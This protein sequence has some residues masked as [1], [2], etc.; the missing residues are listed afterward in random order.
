MNDYMQPESSLNINIGVIQ[1]LENSGNTRTLSPLK[2]VSHE[3]ETDAEATREAENQS[4][5]TLQVEN[6]QVGLSIE[7]I[8]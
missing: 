3:E 7:N 8:G 4:G 5:D 2:Y 6:S 1:S